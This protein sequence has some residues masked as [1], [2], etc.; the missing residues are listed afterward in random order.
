MSLIKRK[1]TNDEGLLFCDFIAEKEA[2]GLS[3]KSIQNYID[4][5]KRFKREMNSNISK[6][7]IQFWIKNYVE[8]GMNPISINF[9]INQIKVF[10]NWLMSNGFIEAFVIKPLKHQESQIKTLTDDELEILL[11]KPLRSCGFIEYRTWVIL[12]FIMATGARA[13]TITNLKVED[14]DFKQKEIVYNYLK[15]KNIA[16]IPLSH[17]LE[18][19]LKRYLYEWDIGNNYLFPNKSGKRLTT[20]ALVHSIRKY[21]IS[22]NL[23]PKGAHSFRHTF[24]K[25]YILNGGNAFTLQRL[26][27]HSDLEMTKKYVRLFNKDLHLGFDDVCPLDILNANKPPKR[28]K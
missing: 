10:A 17:T 28:H 3:K 25:K 6:E 24:A 23:K 19:I 7:S 4:V 26:L 18:T 11:Q 9:Y 13:S 12:N 15:N 14:I 8:S 16:I 20:D 1:H 5:Y 21:F 22:K 27:T 2:S